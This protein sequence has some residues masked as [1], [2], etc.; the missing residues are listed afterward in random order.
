[1]D[2]DKILSKTRIEK[3]DNNSWLFHLPV[4]PGFPTTI[5]EHGS[6]N[7][8]KAKVKA[9]LQKGAEGRGFLSEA[10]DEEIDQRVTKEAKER[11][12][13]GEPHPPE[14]LDYLRSK[15]KQ[16]EV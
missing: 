2:V 11:E 15:S 16:K 5:G 13:K 10:D 4:V 1:M 6:E 9:R 3:V 12:K 14:Y 8:A 7:E